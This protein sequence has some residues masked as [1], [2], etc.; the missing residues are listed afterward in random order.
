MGKRYTI[1]TSAYGITGIIGIIGAFV[2]AWQHNLFL[3]IICILI[4]LVA[5]DNFFCSAR[6]NMGH[7]AVP[8]FLRRK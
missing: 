5:A 3:T 6:A 2:F 7:Y 8:K 4:F 1:S